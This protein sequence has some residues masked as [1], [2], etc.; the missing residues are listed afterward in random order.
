MTSNQTGSISIE[1]DDWYLHVFTEDYLDIPLSS[2]V[3]GFTKI[4]E[5]PHKSKFESH[6][7]KINSWRVLGEWITFLDTC[8]IK[9]F[10]NYTQ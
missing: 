4:S 10:Q 6:K 5:Y 2:R 1:L 3:S 8:Y 7:S 9:A